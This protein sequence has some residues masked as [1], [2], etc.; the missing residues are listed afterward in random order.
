M[1]YLLTKVRVCFALGLSNIFYVVLHRVRIKLGFYSLQSSKAKIPTEPFFVKKPF[2]KINAPPILSW[3]K[4]ALLFGHLPFHV[5]NLS[6]SWFVNPLSGESKIS[7]NKAWWLIP[8]FDPSVGDIKLIW[9]LSRMDWVLAFSQRARNG[10]IKAL[11]Q[12]NNWLADWTFHN[13]PNIGPNWK[14]GQE[15]SIR[16]MHL[17]IA[18][19]I[20]QQEHCPASGL[21]NLIKIHLERIFSTFKYAIAQDNNHGTSE[22][23]ALFIGGSWLESTGDTDGKKW[24]KLG[25]YWLENRAKMLIG[26]QGSFSQYSLNYHRAM[27][28]TY[29]IAE[30]WRLQLKLPAFSLALQDRIK[31]AA[32]W[33]QHFINPFNGDGPNLGS[34]DGANFLPLTN[35]NYRDFRPSVQLA[36][37]LFLKC[38]FMGNYYISSPNKKVKSSHLYT[39]NHLL[40][41]L[42]IA[43]PKRLSP[44]AKNLIADDGGFAILRRGNVMAMLRYPRFKF[45]P[46]Q[47][48]AL[49]LDLWLGENNVLKDAGSY[50]YN[51]DLHWINYFG[52]TVSHNT[53]EFDGC[54][55][56][57]RLG[58]FLFGDWLKTSFLEPLNEGKQRT[59]FSAGYQDRQGIGHHRTIQL[60]D[61]HLIV[62][63]KA[64]GFKT[65]AILRWRITPGKWNIS[66]NGAQYFFECNEAIMNNSLRK[67]FIS[68]NVPIIRCEIVHGWESR[69]YQ[70]KI[71]AT[72]LEV[73]I[74]QHGNIT[75]EFKW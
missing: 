8:D 3:H 6:P 74:M 22:A 34:N 57:P 23:A 39:W 69:F 37:A 44:I 20:L 9:E 63:D 71:Q 5:T 40:I 55:Q 45:R 38:D 65:R 50:S 43:I 48:D 28:D 2:T 25:R 27:L 66:F 10:D 21:V 72:I 52:G 54:D 32:Q 64:F 1:R 59:S 73:E 11:K 61:S 58:R 17:A 4:A 47:S 67:I 14:C 36:M 35:S 70:E 15:A 51:A 53:I 46:N 42:N 41:W 12:L 26:L 13:P 16:V 49:H 62:K 56:M 60:S 19:I 29:S 31:L 33:L 75:S 68:A 24:A 30:I 7:P 18:A